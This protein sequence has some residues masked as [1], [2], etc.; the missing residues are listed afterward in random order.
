ME[1]SEFPPEATG[2]SETAENGQVA[3]TP[4]E[5]AAAALAALETSV[6][7]SAPGEPGDLPP[8]KFDRTSVHRRILGHITDETNVTAL[9]P[10]NTLAALT[11]DLVRAV[12]RT[13]PPPGRP[14]L[15]VEGKN[16]TEVAQ[17]VYDHID[18][19]IDAGLVVQREDGTYAMTDEG[20]LEL[21][22]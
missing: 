1:A 13:H 18:A 3:Q 21:A 12:N 22:S 2:A 17:L 11:Y 9:G 5:Q 14:R 8:V 19:L 10:R 16:S 6:G 15:E 7:V 4:V 20:H